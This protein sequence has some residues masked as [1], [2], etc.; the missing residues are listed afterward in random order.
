MANVHA[1]SKPVPLDMREPFFS[2]IAKI[3]RDYLD[4]RSTYGIIGAERFAVKAAR[5]AYAT[6]PELRC[7]GCTLAVFRK[8]CPNDQHALIAY[9]QDW[10]DS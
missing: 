1:D 5:H 8:D 9:G 7:T 4:K 2:S 3:I 6:K 10:G